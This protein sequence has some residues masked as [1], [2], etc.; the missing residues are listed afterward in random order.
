MS[1]SYRKKPYSSHYCYRS[2]K[3]WKRDNNRRMR[4][5]VHQRL[6]RWGETDD[7]LVLPIMK[8]ISNIWDSP[9]EG[10]HW[11]MDWLDYMG[12]LRFFK[13]VIRK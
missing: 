6:N 1:R 12:E 8:E 11:F 9:S 3:Q 7:D 4:R 13:E 2:E 10:K 5:I